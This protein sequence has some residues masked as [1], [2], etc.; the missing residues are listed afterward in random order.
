MWAN[1]L[2]MCEKKP[3]WYEIIAPESALPDVI[4]S[5]LADNDDSIAAH[6]ALGRIAARAETPSRFDPQDANDS[7]N[8]II[9]A[10]Q[11]LYD[12]V[13]C[14]KTLDVV[15]IVNSQV[16]AAL[17]TDRIST[18]VDALLSKTLFPVR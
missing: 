16:E 6:V 17:L 9:A 14:S 13:A 4:V 7:L 3:S 18:L 15:K 11:A 2:N 8:R 5:V 10:Q 12:V 1:V